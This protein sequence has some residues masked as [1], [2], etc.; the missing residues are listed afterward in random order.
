MVYNCILSRTI[1]VFLRNYYT[2]FLGDY[3]D[4]YSHE[5]RIN[6]PLAPH[7][8]HHEL[9]FCIDN[10]HSHWCTMK[11]RRNLTCRSLMTQDILSVFPHIWVSSIDNSRFGYVAHFPELFVLLIPRFLSSLYIFK[12]NLL[13]DAQLVKYFF[14][15]VICCFVQ[16]AVSFDIQKLLS[17]TR[18]WLLIVDLSARA[19]D[20]LLSKSFP[21]L[22]SPRIPPHFYQDQ[23]FWFHINVTNTFKQPKYCSL[24]YNEF[25]Y[26]LSLISVKIFK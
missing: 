9:P 21:V 25:K 20:V 18:S 2:D 1:Y 26:F 22:R 19:N 11:S 23:F 14:H 13:S 16:L 24:K 3:M 5:Q 7:H 8:H 15:S 12:S 4:F 6:F 17:F 10:S